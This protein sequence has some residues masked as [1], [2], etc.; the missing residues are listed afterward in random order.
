MKIAAAPLLAGTELQEQINL[1]TTSVQSGVVRYRRLAREAVKRG[2]GAQLKP[3]ERLMV[4]WLPRLAAEITKL[5]RVFLSGKSTRGVVYWGPLIVAIPAEQMALIALDALLGMALKADKL[6]YTS[7]CSAIGAAVMAEA[8]LA[9][10]K[11][12]MRKD[13]EHLDRKDARRA[14]VQLDNLL[15]RTDAAKQINRTARKKGALANDTLVHRAALGDRL[16]HLIAREVALL[17]HEEGEKSPDE[18]L[19]FKIEVE[20]N[21]RHKQRTIRLR[22]KTLRIIEEGHSARQ[23]L[24]PVYLPMV[25]PPYRRDKSVPG[26][27]ITIHTPF[28][29]K[30]TPEQQAAYKDA[31]LSF[32]YE[33]LTALG[34]TAHR[35]NTPVAEVVKR[36]A[37]EGGGLL[38]I[39]P[40]HDELKPP[41]PAEADTDKAVARK[42][43]REAFE[44]HVQRVANRAARENF[45]Q[46]GVVAELFKDR[47]AFYYP[48]NNDFRGRTYPIPQHLNPQGTDLCRGMLTFSRSVEPDPFWIQVHVANCAGYDKVSFADRAA[49]AQD[50][51]ADHSVARWIGTTA[52]I[53]DHIDEWGDETQIDSPWQFLAGLIAMHDDEWA[54]RLPVQLD[55]SCN[56]LQHY[57]MMTRDEELAAIVNLTPGDKPAGIYGI[58]AART[59]EILR[60]ETNPYAAI[61]APLVDKDIVKQPTMTTVYGVTFAG[62]REQVRGVLEKKG[63]AGEHLFP[64]AQYLTGIVL[65]AIEG[66]CGRAAPAMAWLRDCAAEF[67]RL[68]LPYRLTTPTGLPMLQSYRKWGVKQLRVMDGTM[69][70]VLH[71]NPCPVATGRQKRGAAPN[72]VHGIDQAHMKRVAVGAWSRGIDSKFVHDGF[73]AHSGNIG[74]GG[75]KALVHA[76]FVDLHRTDWLRAFY[77]E[78]RT[79]YPEARISEPPPRGTFDI[80]GV[81]NAVYAFH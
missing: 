28:V 71:D 22:E 48:H 60:G 64:M 20:S 6:K 69:K 72:T 61:L 5:R 8:N 44:W 37:V 1:E 3:V 52:G 55:G 73:C 50:W 9:Y 81:I 41:R 18:I 29:T 25:V 7:T 31:D 12:E 59:V 40:A 34:S 62:A 42:W 47:E 30:S 66:L 43:K 49:W 13:A 27:Y 53:L 19:A 33:A 14:Q 67:A 75:F 77:D 65:R 38:E 51:A 11:R 10:L 4:A 80:E 76:Q 24:R 70:I 35:I 17:P 68:G 45:A 58:V 2:R 46:L 16:V 39:P 56:G 15:D 54:A 63:V 21:G 74:L 26:G 79:I 36:L 23:R 78:W 32:E 57:A